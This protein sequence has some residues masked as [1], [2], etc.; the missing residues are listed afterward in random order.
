MKVIWVENSGTHLGIPPPVP[1]HAPSLLAL[2]VLDNLVVL[3]VVL[4]R[5]PWSSAEAFCDLKL[6]TFRRYPGEAFLVAM[7]GESAAETAEALSRLRQGMKE[8]FCCALSVSKRFVKQ[9][10]QHEAMEMPW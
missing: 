7:Q 2:G 3:G 5:L 6:C 8:R 1:P 10:S 9:L 4:C